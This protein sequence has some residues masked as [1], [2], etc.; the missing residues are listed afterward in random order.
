MLGSYYMLRNWSGPL[1]PWILR[2]DI[3]QHS[4][5]VKGSCSLLFLS[6][7]LGLFG[8]TLIN[9]SKNSVKVCHVRY[10]KL[11]S[12]AVVCNQCELSFQILQT[13]VKIKETTLVSNVQDSE[14]FT[15]SEDAG[16]AWLGR[17]QRRLPSESACYWSWTA[18]YFWMFIGEVRRHWNHHVQGEA[19]HFFNHFLSHGGCIAWKD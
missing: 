13:K 1:D 18:V 10:E 14:T 8:V 4:T 3:Y 7:S 11:H 15:W 19:S 5:I 2:T 17:A 16:L 12:A 6:C 9:V